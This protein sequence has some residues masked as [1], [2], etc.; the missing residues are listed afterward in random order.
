MSQIKD[1]TK[2][3]FV[4]VPNDVIDEDT[5]FSDATEKMIYLVLKRHANLEGEQAYPSMATI[6]KKALCSESTAKRKVKELIRKGIITKENRYL[7]MGGKTSNMYT[8]TDF[9][10]WVTVN[11]AKVKL[12]HGDGSERPIPQ[13]TVNHKEDTT[14]KTPFKDNVHSTNVLD[15]FENVWK[16]YPL[17]KKKKTAIEAYKRAKKKG[18]EDTHIINA[19]EAYKK[20]MQLPENS[21][22]SLQEG[23]TWFNQERWD[24]DYSNTQQASSQAAASS[25][26]AYE[27]DHI[28]EAT[29]KWSK[30]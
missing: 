27:P 7:E 1:K 17:K 16:H 30:N 8:I 28:E 10:R 25:L 15:S 13:V 9:K 3:P 26:P 6:A 21:W 19:I 29:F 5:V 23:G 24:D 2:Y 4:M 12:N 11:H 14:I 20:E 18:V 22:R